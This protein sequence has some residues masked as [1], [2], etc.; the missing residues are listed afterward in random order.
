[1][2][3]FCFPLVSTACWMQLPAKE[4]CRKFL[5]ESCAQGPGLPKTVRNRN[6]G[7]PS[8]LVVQ[9]WGPSVSESFGSGI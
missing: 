2:F 7:N 5:K 6:W 9:D 1:M 4:Q 3:G 8:S